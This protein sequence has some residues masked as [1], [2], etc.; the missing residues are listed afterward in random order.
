MAEPNRDAEE[1]PSTIGKEVEAIVERIRK[2]DELINPIHLD[3]DDDE[4]GEW[5]EDDDEYDRAIAKIESIDLTKDDF[6][7]DNDLKNGVSSGSRA[8]DLPRCV[9]YRKGLRNPCLCALHERSTYGF[10]LQGKVYGLK[11]D[12]RVGRY[13]VDFIEVTKIYEN[14]T[15]GFVIVRGVP[16]TRTRNMDGRLAPYKN[17]VCRILEIESND[18]RHVDEQ[19]LIEVALSSIDT[20]VARDLHKTNKCFPECRYDPTVYQTK[21][22]REEHA[23]LACRWEL[24]LTYPDKRYRRHQRPIDGEMLLHFREKDVV[25]DRH[26]TAD[27]KELV[28]WRGGPTVRGGSRTLDVLDENSSFVR[29]Y[30]AADMFSGAGGFTTGAKKAGFWVERA[31]DHWPRANGTY[32]ANHPEVEL[33]ETDI[34]KYCDDLTI[35]NLAV[36]LVHLSPPCQTWSPAHT[37][38]GRNDSANIAALYACKHIIYKLRPRLITFE[39]TFGII[40]DR[41]LP[42]FNALLQSLTSYGYSFMWKVVRLVDFGLPQTR[43]RLIM[44]GA[45]RGHA[46]PE[47]PEPTHSTDPRGPQRA[48]VSAHKACASLVDGDDL[49]DVSGARGLDPPRRAWDS[50][51]P[52]NRTIT[53]SGGQAYHWGGEREFTLAEFKMLQGFPKKYIFVG[54]CVKKQIGNAFPPVVVEPIA[55]HLL[56]FLQRLD[57]VKPDVPVVISIDSSDSSDSD[58]D[59][60]GG[61]PLHDNDADGTIN[62]SLGGHETRRISLPC[63][64]PKKESSHD[65]ATGHSRNF[66]LDIN[67]SLN[68]DEALA[69]ALYESAPGLSHNVTSLNKGMSDQEALNWALYESSRMPNKSGSSHNQQE[70]VESILGNQVPPHI[71]LTEDEALAAALYESGQALNES[72]RTE[73]LRADQNPDNVVNR[74]GFAEHQAPEDETFHF[75]ND[76]TLVDEDALYDKEAAAYDAEVGAAVVGTGETSHPPDS[77]PP[78]SEQTTNAEA[79]CSSAAHRPSSIARR[80]EAAATER[81]RSSGGSSVMITGVRTLT[82]VIEDSDEEKQ[83]GDNAPDDGN[84]GQ[85]PLQHG[86]LSGGTVDDHTSQDRLPSLGDTTSPED[87]DD[88]DL[89]PSDVHIGGDIRAPS[90]A[91]RTTARSVP[92]S[93]QP[94]RDVAVGGEEGNGDESADDDN[95]DDD[96]MPGLGYYQAHHPLPGS[97]SRAGAGPPPASPAAP[98]ASP[99]GNV[100]RNPFSRPRTGLGAASS[101]PALDQW[102]RQLDRPAARAS[103][104][105]A[106]VPGVFDPEDFVPAEMDEDE[107]LAAALAASIEEEVARVERQNEADMRG[108]GLGAGTGAGGATAGESSAAGGSSTARGHTAAAHG[109]SARYGSGSRPGGLDTRAAGSGSRAPVVGID[110]GDFGRRPTH[111]NP[112]GPAPAETARP[113]G[114][115]DDEQEEAYEGKGKGK[116]VSKRPYDG[117]DDTEEAS[118]SKRGRTGSSK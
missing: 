15:S 84:D 105:R 69:A 78:S 93:N 109:P 85:E 92:A 17:E 49:H 5:E 51:R 83:H 54:P 7:D 80:S 107:L 20:K 37:S 9:H 86:S 43:K 114:D 118:P 88:D 27:K 26:R 64:E 74:R 45:A 91:F 48:L 73:K 24:R 1:P 67:A 108:L 6:D 62:A 31:V 4:V 61:A 32:K 2:G 71:D 25:K 18:D 57:G 40:Q 65:V 39:Q 113:A 94:Y 14:P 3:E 76:L 8:T 58:S 99:A 56:R 115:D 110:L 44:I 38:P 100:R 22:E 68:E 106:V 79:T 70:R 81:R 87:W 23:P 72:V 104:S 66:D 59:S 10:L 82:T 21:T 36:D 11:E 95:D 13:P 29:R 34:M 89:D 101:L 33:F 53:T 96:N 42:Y 50:T 111:F 46:L 30:N 19:S 103:S 77:T 98:P 16:Y 75:E 28:A 112:F 47:W 41:H 12:V 35:D 97:S 55:K 52:M 102:P 116:A 117:A 60:G 63:K 90:S